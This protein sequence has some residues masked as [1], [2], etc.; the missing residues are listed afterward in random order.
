[1]FVEGFIR[2]NWYSRRV[3]RVR[4]ELTANGLKDHCPLVY[5]NLFWQGIAKE[6]GIKYWPVKKAVVDFF[7]QF[8]D[9]GLV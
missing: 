9:E 2:E 8:I 6:L 1:M 3:T 4:L 5:K 7:Q